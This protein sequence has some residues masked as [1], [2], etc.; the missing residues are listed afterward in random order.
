MF[1]DP[2][3]QLTIQR[4]PW[5]GTWETVHASRWNGV[6]LDLASTL[7]QDT[8]NAFLYGDPRDLAR[9]AASV[10]KTARRHQRRFQG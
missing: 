3:W 9:A 8:V 5:G 1:A 10:A 4:K 7:E 6:M 2:V